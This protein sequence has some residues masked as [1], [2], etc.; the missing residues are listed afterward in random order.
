MRVIAFDTATALTAVS[1][2]D[3]PGV[4][5]LARVDD[6][7]PGARPGHA[8]R[9]LSLINAVL[10]E[11][12]GGW[13]GVDR[14]AVGVGPGTFTGLRIGI[15]TAQALARSAS[16]PVVGVS[17]LS[18][19][20]VA[21]HDGERAIITAIDA[22]RGEVFVAAWAAD[23]DPLTA[24]PALRPC[25]I[26]PDQLPGLVQSSGTQTIAVGDGAL[27]FADE[28][29]SAGAILPAADSPLHRVSAREHCR[30]AQLAN[31]SSNSNAVQP[32]YLRIPDAELSK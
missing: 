23:Q 21:A 1:L 32:Q 10:T 8:S 17:T 2:R 28:L 9:L 26:R 29:L 6:P 31:A 20:A 14:I 25:V 3:I 4:I 12:G 15:A 19:L 24:Q 16:K 13:S 27:K 7:P 22:R 5:D 18:S 11:A 30:L